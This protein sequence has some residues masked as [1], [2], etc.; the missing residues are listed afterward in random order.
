MIDLAIADPQIYLRIYLPIDPPVICRESRTPEPQNPRT[1]EPQ[2]PQNP[3]NPGAAIL[4]TGLS[5]GGTRAETGD[6]GSA[7]S[8]EP[9]HVVDRTGAKGAAQ[10]RHWTARAEEAGLRALRAL[11]SPAPRWWP[12]RRRHGCRR[13]SSCQPRRRPSSRRKR[14]VTANGDFVF[15]GSM[16]GNF[17]RGYAGFAEFVKGDGTARDLLEGPALRLH[18]PLIVKTP[19]IAPDPAKAAQQIGKQL[20]LGV[21]GVM[22]VVGRERRRSAPGAR[23]DALQVEGRHA[24]RGRRHRA[25]AL[26]HEREGVQGEGRSLAAQPRTASSSTGPSSRARPV[27]PRCARSRR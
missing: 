16:E 8:D 18:H 17:D 3:Q 12:A 6:G 25:G 5:E 15:D 9:E 13:A 4:T 7:G 2:N 14:W 26:G 27:W 24:A 22:F 1:S 23:G 20:N 21:S 19:E 10:P 11:Q